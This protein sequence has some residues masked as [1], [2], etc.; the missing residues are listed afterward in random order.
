MP[1]LSHHTSEIVKELQQRASGCNL[2]KSK[3][4]L[5]GKRVMSDHKSSHSKIGDGGMSQ[6]Q[7]RSKE[8]GNLKKKLLEFDRSA[9]GSRRGRLNVH[10]TRGVWNSAVHANIAG[11]YLV[12]ERV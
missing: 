1:W 3:D 11:W 8:A 5:T 2:P 4:V 10:G 9:E 6:R 7:T 12:Q